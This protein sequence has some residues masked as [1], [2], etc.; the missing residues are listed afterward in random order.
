MPAVEEVILD[1]LSQI[2]RAWL[3][4]QPQRLTA[5]FHPGM[6]MTF[7]GFSGQMQGRQSQVAGF[8]DFCLNATVHD[9]TE[10]QHKVMVIEETAIATY[11]YDMIYER[12][13]QVHRA[14]GRDLWVFQ[15]THGRWLA[16][17]RTMLDTQEYPGNGHDTTAGSS[18]G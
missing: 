8:E 5:L 15:K 18:S 10:T 13:H 16:V 4:K 1:L 7:P 2:N 9:Y 3:E 17:W 6:I 11:L 12:D 14:T